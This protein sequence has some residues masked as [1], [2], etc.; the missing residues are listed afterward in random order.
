MSERMQSKLNVTGNASMRSAEEQQRLMNEYDDV[1]Y[2]SGVDDAA[3][4]EAMAKRDYEKNVAIEG[5]IMENATA[6]R[7]YMMAQQIAELKVKGGSNE[8]VSDKEDK[9]QELLLAY[10][11]NADAGRAIEN[12]NAEQERDTVKGNAIRVEKQIA[13]EEAHAERMEEV[14]FI[15]NATEQQASAVEVE[16]TEASV[17]TAEADTPEAE[18]TSTDEQQD[19]A[20]EVVDNEGDKPAEVKLTDDEIR[21]K[22]ALMVKNGLSALDV[23]NMSDAEISSYNLVEKD[24]SEPESAEAAE[25][26]SSVGEYIPKH[27]AN[28][29]EES[30]IFDELK[31]ELEGAGV[32]EGESLEEFEARQPGKHSSTGAEDLEIL[33]ADAAA[34]VA[35][36]TS[37]DDLEILDTGT[38]ATRSRT[39]RIRDILDPAGAGIAAELSA[40][41]ATRERGGRRGRIAAALGG[42]AL[43]I[44]GGLLL[45]K[46]H[47]PSAIKEVVTPDVTPPNVADTPLPDG[48]GGGRDLVETVR[49]RPG[50]GEI[51][52]T[53][54]LLE[55]NGVHVNTTEA[56]QIGEHANVHDIL[57]GDA[58]YAHSGS[59]MDR[60]GRTGEFETRKGVVSKLLKAAR[61]LGY[62]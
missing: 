58:S 2:E 4:E 27:R 8:I 10:A 47:D 24:L 6:R 23:G 50:D 29:D 30:P 17:E 40:S 25:A 26:D 20:P 55:S 18:G 33:G 14:D 41:V 39:R 5:R 46:G 57:K 35:D 34:G 49:V 53:Q 45:F 21:A 15:L 37:V 44:G 19:V 12:R 1:M 61:Q 43:L 56:Q 22:R 28:R 51:K 48:N 60:I 13:A 31:A 62:K 9:L 42:A 38:S 16:A 54:S 36:G 59:S 11:D 52:V 32:K 7:M 3:Y